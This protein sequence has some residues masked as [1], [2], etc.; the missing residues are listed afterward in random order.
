MKEKAINVSE[1]TAEE[2]YVIY[3]VRSNPELWKVLNKYITPDGKVRTEAE[4][5]RLKGNEGGVFKIED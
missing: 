3:K 2:A 1:I 5:R 4:V